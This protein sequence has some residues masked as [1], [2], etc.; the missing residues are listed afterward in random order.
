MS[1]GI[2]L[3]VFAVIVSGCTRDSTE[4]NGGVPGDIYIRVFE[5]YVSGGT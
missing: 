5:N 1:S 4:L 3:T 2:A